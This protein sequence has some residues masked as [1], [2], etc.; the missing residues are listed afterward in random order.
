MLV[1]Y[2]IFKKKKAGENREKTKTL[3]ETLRTLKQ[4]LKNDGKILN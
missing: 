2:K 3:E 4:D 1:Y